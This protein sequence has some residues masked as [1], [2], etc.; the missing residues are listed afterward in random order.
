MAYLVLLITKSSG[1]VPS[2]LEIAAAAIPNSRT[3]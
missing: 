1:M 2:N 3:A